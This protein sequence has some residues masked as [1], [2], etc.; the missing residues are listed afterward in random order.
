MDDKQIAKVQKEIEVNVQSRCPHRFDDPQTKIK[1]SCGLFDCHCVAIDS[2]YSHIENKKSICK[3]YNS[4]VPKRKRKKEVVKTS[5]KRC[6][7]CNK[8]YI[9]S[10]KRQKYCVSCAD[11]MKKKYARDRK[12][13]ERK[14]KVEN[15]TNLM[16]NVTL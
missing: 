15:Y 12:Q 11:I 10:G 14:G 5:K 1:D 4:L 3:I 8:L 6:V 9:P 16:V 13:S 7:N 2:V